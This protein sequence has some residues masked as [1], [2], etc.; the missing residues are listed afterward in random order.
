MQSNCKNRTLQWI[1]KQLKNGNISLSH[2]LQRKEGQWNRRTKSELIDSLLRD[3]P[4]NPTYAIKENNILSLID[5]VQRI[6]TI[7][8]YLSDS[9]A[10]SKTLEP[11]IIKNNTD[12]GI[13][14]ME[15]VIAG[16]KF[17]KLD[18]N[19]QDILL[20]CE[21]QIYELTD[22]T[23]KDVREMFRR[24]NSGKVLN[25]TQLRSVMETDEMS[26]LIYLVTSHPFF[27][28]IL[29][30]AQRRKDLEKDIF[31]QTLMLIETTAENDYTSFKNKNINDFILMY[32]ENISYNNI[33][34]LEQ[35]LDKLDK[36]FD[37]LKIKQLNIPMILFSAYKVI[38]YNKSF[39]EFVNVIHN[40]VETYD[41]NE[42]Y[43]KFCLNGTS[44]PENV[45]GRLD[46][47]EKAIKEL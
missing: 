34:I 21:L 7:R 19:I 15:V 14:E 6:S 32:Q 24:Q 1:N 42:E 4:I 44:S 30:P 17:S 3:Y 47:W 38:K 40:F 12:D 46:Y 33:D 5:G 8:D 16:K 9:F 45:R 35:A 27:E 18:E 43:K 26:D 28:K 10:L 23:E 22:C 25:N 11:V 29:T 31:V 36:N 37:K 41:T 13:V 2:K 20:A 39:D